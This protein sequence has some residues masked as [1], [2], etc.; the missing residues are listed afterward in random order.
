MR[1]RFVHQGGKCKEVDDDDDDDVVALKPDANECYLVC[2]SLDTNLL[3]KF[4]VHTY[5]YSSLSVKWMMGLFV[6]P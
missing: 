1:I 2:K 3:F 4:T 5:I 6:P